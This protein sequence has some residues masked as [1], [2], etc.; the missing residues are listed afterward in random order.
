[1]VIKALEGL[2]G[3]TR[4]QVRFKEKRAYVTYEKGVVT[5]EQMIK[6]VRQAGFQASLP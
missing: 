5:I 1:M 3:V 4:A 6:A 2:K